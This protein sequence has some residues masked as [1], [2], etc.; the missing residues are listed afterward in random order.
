MKQILID[1]STMAAK[2]LAIPQEVENIKPEEQTDY[3]SSKM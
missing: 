1:F 3:S 2:R